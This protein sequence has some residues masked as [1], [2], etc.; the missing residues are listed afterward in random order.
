MRYN[1]LDP[2]LYYS[3][4]GGRIEAN[5][6]QSED[7]TLSWNLQGAETASLNLP[8]T[9]VDAFRLVNASGTP[10]MQCNDGTLAIWE[11]RLENPT[12][13]DEGSSLEALGYSRALQDIPYTALWSDTSAANWRP[14]TTQDNAAFPSE[15]YRFD[16]QDRLHIAA[17]KGETF[18]NAIIGCFGYATPSG[19][20]RQILGL[21]FDYA[22]QAPVNWQFLVQRR[23]SAWGA[24]ATDLAINATGALITGSRAYALPAASDNLT[25]GLYYNA[26]AAVYGGETDA[27]F[28]TITNFRVVT[29]TTNMIATTLTANRAA[30]VNVTA[31]VGSTARMYVGQRLSIV[32]AASESVIVLSIGSG[33]QFNAT[34]V[35]AYVIG[36][37]VQGHI[38]YADEVA[39]NVAVAVN[40]VNSVQLSSSSA[41]IQSPG[42]DLPDA[43]WQD[44]YGADVLSDLA[45]RGDT[46]TAPRRWVWSVET[47]RLLRFAP[48]GD[49]GR[50]W[51]VD[52]ADLTVQLSRENLQND[53]YPVYQDVAGATVRGAVNP[54]TVSV[55]RYGLTRRLAVSTNTTDAVQATA[56]A[57]TAIT[58]GAFPTPKVQVNF[59]AVFDAS[60]ARWPLYLIRPGDTIF[61]R[62]LP[63]TLSTSVDQ[64]RSFTVARSEYNLDDDTVG[65]EPLDPLPTLEAALSG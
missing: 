35:N 3:A 18:S 2:A 42:R 10:H 63:P 56:A 19:G 21:A 16:T 55:A 30:G 8:L 15:K 41:L 40:A 54:S 7:V 13:T 52:A 57:N 1:Q 45:Q 31:T 9:L 12:M 47:G 32:G 17:Q 29:S 49:G 59:T 65:V 44:Q 43:F 23:T 58:I 36:N 60:G 64:I 48:L 61:I 37:T 38:V 27:T 62:N 6:N 25:F 5:M 46:Q 14:L 51:Y 50:T 4:G 11:G 26:A 34:F 53:A 33:T 28:I 20:A 22:F 24:V 39:A